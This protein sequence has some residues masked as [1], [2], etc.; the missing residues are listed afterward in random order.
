MHELS[1]AQNILD[2]VSDQCVRSG[3][4]RVESINLRV[5]RASGIMPDALL[6]AFDAIKS[7]SIARGAV[8]HIEEVPVSGH[9]S[10][11]LQSFMVEEE[12]I[13]TC[14]LCGGRDFK[15]TGGREM[16]VIDMEVS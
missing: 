2:I 13:L 7:D 9:C 5:G 6:F 11:C 15:V 10:G 16:E 8:L 14:P 4:K 12:Y 3:Y 1:L